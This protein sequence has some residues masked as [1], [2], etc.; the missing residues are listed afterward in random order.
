VTSDQVAA[1]EPESATNAIASQLEQSR[2][3]LAEARIAW[4]NS[5]ERKRF[6]R[7]CWLIGAA[8]PFFLG[9]GALWC[10]LIEFQPQ[11]ENYFACMAAGAGIWFITCAYLGVPLSYIGARRAFGDRRL[12]EK[13]HKE[14]VQAES[15]ISSGAT[16]F[17]SLWT[18]TQ[19]RLDYDHSSRAELPVWPG[20]RR[21][22]IYYNSDKRDCCG[23]SQFHRRI[24]QL[25]RLRTHRRRPWSFH[26]CYIHEIPE[27]RFDS[28]SRIFSPTPRLL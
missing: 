21:C 25:C 11:G 14:L 23:T 13:E 15:E 18:V 24:H 20:R 12:L 8:L 7:N 3:E 19:K 9:G 5:G 26:R 17:Q 22:R 10:K 28:A 1:V 6:V 4:R 2:I 27:Y 16:D